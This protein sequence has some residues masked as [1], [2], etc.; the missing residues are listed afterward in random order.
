[1]IFLLA[2]SAAISIPVSLVV[3]GLLLVVYFIFSFLGIL[4]NPKFGL[5]LM[6]SLLFAGTG[7]FF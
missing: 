1:M 6:N 2:I 4:Q 3:N 7:L 5:L